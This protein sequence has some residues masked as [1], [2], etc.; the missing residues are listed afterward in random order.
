M[1]RQFSAILDL[2]K[3]FIVTDSLL[4]KAQ[5]TEMHSDWDVLCSKNTVQCHLR[6]MPSVMH[7]AVPPFQHMPLQRGQLYLLRRI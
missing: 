7:G 2:N 4:F 6:L 3:R 1:L 5:F